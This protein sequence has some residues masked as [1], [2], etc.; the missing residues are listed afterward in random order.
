[1]IFLGST[2]RTCLSPRIAERG[3]TMNPVSP[4]VF[5]AAVTSEGAIA[6]CASVVVAVCAPVRLALLLVA[7]ELPQ[8]PARSATMT[9]RK[10]LDF[11]RDESVFGCTYPAS[12]TPAADLIAS[13]ARTEPPS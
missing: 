12:V 13:P 10:I 6:L 2:P 9:T 11:R 1:M 3:S 5:M 4:I 7:R 8:A